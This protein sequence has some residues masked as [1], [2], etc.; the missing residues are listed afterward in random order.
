MRYVL[1]STASTILLV[2]LTTRA[3][4]PVE[5]DRTEYYGISWRPDGTDLILSHSGLDN[6]SLVDIASYA[7][8]ERGWI[9]AGDRSSGIFLSA[10]HQILCLPDGRIACTNTGRNAITIIDLDRPGL[11][12]EARISAQRWDRL[13]PDDAPGDHLNSVFEKNGRLYVI[14]H[15]FTKGSQLA[16]LSL[17]DCKVLDVRSVGRMTGLHNIWVTEDGRKISCH[18]EA[19]N[20]IDLENNKVLW[21]SGAPIYTR[22][23]AASADHILVG[24]S[25]KTPRISRSHSMSGLW[26]LDRRTWQPSDYFCLGPYGVVHEVRLLD[27]PDEAHHGHIFQGLNALLKKDMR[28]EIEG[29]QLDRS[30][31]ALG[32][33]GFHDSYDVIF[34]APEFLEEGTLRADIANLCL[35]LVR[36]A[37][38]SEFEL[39]YGLPS[40]SSGSHVSVVTGY[41]GSGGDTH[42]AALLLQSAGGEAHLSVWR[43]DG[44]SPWAPLQRASIA[45]LPRSGRLTVKAGVDRI[46]VTLNNGEAITMKAKDLGI[47][48]CNEGLGLRWIGADIKPLGL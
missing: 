44:S 12:Q 25:L 1:V 38:K 32:L 18:S 8:S 6:R 4:T 34:G 36:D 39:E 3:V 20:L 27:V 30:R 2:D 14:A 11:F 48:R 42:M 46:T 9:S 5:G 22:G 26:V 41:H 43:H 17:P 31:K 45:H 40:D 37:S 33:R 10:P 15:R 21:E 19:G 13:T 47:A 28:R 35:A 29:R 16:T 24:E 7:Q 23:L